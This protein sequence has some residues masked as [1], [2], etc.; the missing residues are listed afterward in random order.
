MIGYM[1]LG[2]NDLEKYSKFYDELFTIIGASRVMHD[3]HITLWATKPELAMFAL[4]TPNNK[5]M[6]SVGNG[7][8]TAFKVKDLETIRL[9][10]AKAI[11]LGGTDEGEP[12]PRGDTLDFGYVR[13]LEGNKLAFY[14]YKT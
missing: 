9:L 1:T 2:T 10:H 14:C 8:M 11:E 4:I 13:D 7:T 5:K 12:G 3:D 6:A